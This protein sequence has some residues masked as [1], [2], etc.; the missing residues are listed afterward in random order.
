[1][2]DQISDNHVLLEKSLVFDTGLDS[3]FGS[4]AE[5][6]ADNP[7]SSSRRQASKTSEG[8]LVE[9][10]TVESHVTVETE[11]LSQEGSLTD[12]GSISTSALHTSE[13]SSNSI[14]FSSSC[15]S[16]NSDKSN[17]KAR[18]QSKKASKY[19]ALLREPTKRK[20]DGPPKLLPMKT[21]V[22][23]I[24]DVKKVPKKVIIDPSQSLSVD[25]GSRRTKPTKLPRRIKSEGDRKDETGTAKKLSAPPVDPSTTPI[26]RNRGSRKTTQTSRLPRKI[27]SEGDRL[28]R[29]AAVKTP[30][31]PLSRDRG[32]RCT[33][34]RTIKRLPPKMKSEGDRVSSI[35]KTPRLPPKSKTFAARAAISILMESGGTVADEMFSTAGADS[36]LR[37]NTTQQ[38]GT[39]DTRDHR[40]L[41]TK[42][43]SDIGLQS[44]RALPQRD[45]MSP[46]RTT[47]KLNNLRKGIAN[48]AAS[49][50]DKT[51]NVQHQN[52]APNLS[53]SF[54]NIKWEESLSAIE[55]WKEFRHEK[56]QREERVT[57]RFHKSSNDIPAFFDWEKHAA[58]LNIGG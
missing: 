4:I 16:L 36:S 50:K 39:G 49:S 6:L 12:F 10:K 7:A 17:R 40:Q 35:T 52:L 42:G 53:K 14:E 38:R 21:I 15:P 1:M 9:F 47:D 11:G 51:E 33:T 32:S 13:R 34:A 27:K 20:D 24:Q 48:L 23:A 54:S 44:E 26:L 57:S 25:R 22:D 45:L 31:V 3:S 56:N 55:R 43:L 29:T 19:K 5:S 8:S 37:V 28:E 18:R 46:I 30:T 58:E 41:L 2:S